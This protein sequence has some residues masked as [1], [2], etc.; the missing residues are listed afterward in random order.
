[1]N[2]V[3]EFTIKVTLIVAYTGIVLWVTRTRN[4]SARFKVWA[5]VMIIMLLLPLWILWGPRARTPVPSF[6][7]PQFESIVRLSGGHSEPVESIS[8]IQAGT[9]SER[10]ESNP[11]WNWKWLSGGAYLIGVCTLFTR[12]LIGT[13][14]ARRLAG[15]SQLQKGFL[16]SSSCATPITLGVFRPVT[17]LPE[18]WVE[19]SSSQLDM[20]L[21]H[22]REHARRRDPLVRWLALFNRAVFWFHPLSWWLERQLSFLAEQ[23]CD[24]AVLAGGHDPRNYSEHLLEMQRVMIRSGKRIRLVGSAM[25]GSFLSKRIERIVEGP[26][27]FS[28]SRRRVTFAIAASVISSGVVAAA[29]LE[30]PVVVIKASVPVHEMQHAAVAVSAIPGFQSRQAAV[31]AVE[32]KWAG[33][34]KLNKSKSNVGQD[35]RIQS[36]L[37]SVESVTVKLEPGPDGVIVKSDLVGIHPILRQQSEFSLKFGVPTSG[38]EV[39]PIL[40]VAY[41]ATVTMIPMSNNVLN[42]TITYLDGSGSQTLRFEVSNDG[43]TLTEF[44]PAPDDFRFVF[45]RQ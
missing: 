27:M 44:L 32:A 35:P 45:Q 24:D 4:A 39:S 12:L 17:I 26:S 18:S 9:M 19:W 29:A 38:K 8:S 1:M 10:S 20:V 3:V 23:A 41:P 25:P 33:T 34:W 11:R 42:L 21:A 15:R 2:F 14:S 40:G 5:S 30:R 7:R 43:N 37:D 16:T 36:M 6:L 22:E 13:A 28:V 31:Q